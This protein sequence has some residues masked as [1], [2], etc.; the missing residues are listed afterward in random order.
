MFSQKKINFRFSSL[1]GKSLIIE[2]N[3]S[4]STNKYLKDKIVG[5][6]FSASWCPPCQ[7]FTP[8]LINFYKKYHQQHNFK[9][10]LIPFKEDQEEEY[11][12]YL[13][14]MP[15]ASLSPKKETLIDSLIKKYRCASVP[16]IVFI[17]QEGKVIKEI[18][19]FRDRNQ[20]I[21]HSS[22]FSLFS[23]LKTSKKKLPKK[24]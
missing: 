6:Y 17:N 4:V 21:N 23:N 7:Q 18:I 8:Q 13:H 3:K 1:F 12:D 24:K 14:Q 16:R 15:W 11:Q 20:I 19:E 5:L 22:S 2:K 10:V 9:I